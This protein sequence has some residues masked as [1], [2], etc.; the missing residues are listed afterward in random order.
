MLLLACTAPCTAFP[1]TTPPP[2]TPQVEDAKRCL[3]LYGNN[4]SAVVKDAVTDLYQLKK[5]RTWG[6]LG[7]GK[8]WGG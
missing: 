8:G 2:P 3:F 7:A 1:S 4:T 6:R 5:V